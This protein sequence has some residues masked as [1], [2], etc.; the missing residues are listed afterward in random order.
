MDNER[1][2]LK[3]YHIKPLGYSSI[4]NVLVVDS[5]SGKYVIKK[6]NNDL[7]SVYNYLK[8]RNF[9]WIP[10]YYNVNEP[11]DYFLEEYINSDDID[12]PKYDKALEIM[13]IISLLHNKTTIYDEVSLDDYKIIYEDINNKINDDVSYYNSLN[14]YIDTV[15]YMS[16][17]EYLLARN[18]S[19]VYAAL[20]FCKNEL[21]SW[22]S[23]IKNS[24]K[25]RKTVIHN[26][27]SLDHLMRKSDG[28]VLVSW[29]HSKYDIPIY[30]L[31]KFYKEIYN[32]VDFQTLFDMYLQ[33]Y[34]LHP[35]EQKLFFILI[36]LPERI[37]FNNDSY[38]N[39]HKIEELLNYIVKT[40][41][42]I[43][44]YYAKDEDKNNQD[45]Y[46]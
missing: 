5:P 35:S 43:S 38:E 32:E 13:N 16:P 6:K 27:L 26:N 20:D 40:E 24:D 44:P 28:S 11:D 19:K 34:P 12:I 23:L 30:D 9:N 29:E 10:D 3:K 37:I 45:F 42:I 36:S 46:E 1:E 4:N 2:I 22:Y 17:A 21:E 8:L 25:Q 41:K 14:N 15:T 18:I 7:S 33:K 31:Y 39:C